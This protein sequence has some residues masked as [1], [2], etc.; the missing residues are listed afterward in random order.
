MVVEAMRAGL[1]GRLFQ[2]RTRYCGTPIQI[3]PYV[4]VG[5]FPDGRELGM[6]MM[7]YRIYELD[8]GDPLVRCPCQPDGPPRDLDQV[9]GTVAPLPFNSNLASMAIP[10][11]ARARS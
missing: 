5:R 3:A 11:I 6:A 10:N 1:P 7:H 4:S 9:A 8:S 2:R